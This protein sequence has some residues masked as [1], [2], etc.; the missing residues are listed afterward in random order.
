[1]REQIGELAGKIWETLGQ[2]G[3]INIAQL[4]KLVKE[5]NEA[6]YQAL[7]WLAHEN[8]IIYSKKEGKSFVMLAPHE[9]EVFKTVH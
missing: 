3:E 4:P 6:T 1:M 5:K 2:R 8:K 9:Q 7:G